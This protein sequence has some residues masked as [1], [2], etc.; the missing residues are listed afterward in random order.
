[1]R[2]EGPVMASGHMA[3]GAGAMSGERMRWRRGSRARRVCRSFCKMKSGCAALAAH[4]PT[5]SLR[6]GTGY[7]F[8]PNLAVSRSVSVGTPS[9][10]SSY[11]TRWKGLLILMT[12]RQVDRVPTITMSTLEALMV[13]S[14]SRI[15][16][17]P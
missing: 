7:F 6:P 1:M 14:R 10:C 13:A 2:D 11:R 16:A 9:S 5:V 3:A 4:R 8:L 15:C 17:S 12:A